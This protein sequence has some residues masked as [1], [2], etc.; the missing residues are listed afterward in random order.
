[1]PEVRLLHS[2]DSN[3]ARYSCT[4]GLQNWNKGE[5]MFER[6]SLFLISRVHD[7][8]ALI[9]LIFQVANPLIPKASVLR[10]GYLTTITYAPCRFNT[11]IHYMPSAS[12]ALQAQ[13]SITKTPK[14]P[15]DY[16]ILH[17]S[18]PS[19]PRNIYQT[20]L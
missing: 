6:W 11:D 19:N 12:V 18:P 4:P 20:N 9:S 14:V 17:P 16:G 15:A 10:S 3:H 2:P 1:M 13:S 7:T 5:N 8:D